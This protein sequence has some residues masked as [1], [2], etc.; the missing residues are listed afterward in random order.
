MDF[1][2]KSTKFQDSDS[3]RLTCPENIY[4]RAKRKFQVS[5]RLGP[6]PDKFERLYSIVGRCYANFKNT[7]LSK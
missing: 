1:Q 2:M 3:E 5:W 7:D 6:A 4:D